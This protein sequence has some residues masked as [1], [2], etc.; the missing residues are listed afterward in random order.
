MVPFTGKE[1]VLKGNSITRDFVMTCCRGNGSQS[2]KVKQNG[3]V[4]SVVLRTLTPSSCESSVC[5]G[6]D[7]GNLQPGSRAGLCFE[8]KV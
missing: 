6:W 4:L 8:G 1:C 5:W 3:D 7:T 2:R